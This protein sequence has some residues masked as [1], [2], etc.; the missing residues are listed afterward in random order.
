MV[1]YEDVSARV[2]RANLEC[3]NGYIHVIDNVIMKVRGSL[4]T[5]CKNNVY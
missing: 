4:H 5:F 2:V 3:S 1:S